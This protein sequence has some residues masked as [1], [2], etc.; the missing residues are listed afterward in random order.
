M[1]TAAT[2]PERHVDKCPPFCDYTEH[3]N[4]SEPDDPMFLHGTEAHGVAG[5]LVRISSSTNGKGEMH[6]EEPVS[7]VIDDREISL[8]ETR[9][10]AHALLDALHKAT[11]AY[12]DV[13]DEFE[14]G[15]LCRSVELGLA[16]EVAN[17]A[18]HER[19]RAARTRSW[20]AR[21]D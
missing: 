13:H 16:A 9:D 18:H 4:I 8:K 20:V 17:H 10:L 7:V 15:D 2:T 11:M 21:T 19:L 1:T 14:H 5:V 6:P 12:R 3:E